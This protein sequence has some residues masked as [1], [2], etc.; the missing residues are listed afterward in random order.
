MSYPDPDSP[1]NENCKGS[2]LIGSMNDGG[3]IIAEAGVVLGLT[4][5]LEE[6]VTLANPGAVVVCLC[7]HG[8]GFWVAAVVDV[9]VATVVRLCHQGVGFWVAAVVRLCHQGA[10]VVV[11]CHQGAAVVVLCHQGAAVVALCHQ[12]GEETHLR[13]L[14]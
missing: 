11:P 8:V 1:R 4:A 3:V 5:R 12:G 6:V 7:H 10:A 2:L 13:P 9:W 14:F